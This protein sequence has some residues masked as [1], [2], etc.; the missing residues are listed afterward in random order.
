[1]HLTININNHSTINNRGSIFTPTWQTRL[2]QFP[3]TSLR[4]DFI[5]L[6]FFFFFF[7]L[8]IRE[9]RAFSVSSLPLPAGL[10][11]HSGL[12]LLVPSSLSPLKSPQGPSFL[13]AT[14]R[15]FFQ[16]HHSMSHHSRILKNRITLF[17]EGRYE[18]A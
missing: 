7:I 2:F 4:F 17:K 6:S 16:N 15:M 10:T 13:C 9:V 12:P 18:K 1:M 11:P 8:P 3:K 5:T 14:C